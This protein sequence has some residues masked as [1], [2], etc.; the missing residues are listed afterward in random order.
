MCK[1]RNVFGR[2][3]KSK[4]CDKVHMSQGSVRDGVVVSWPAFQYKEERLCTQ[5]TYWV[6]PIHTA[7]YQLG[8][9]SAKNAKSKHCKSHSHSIIVHSCAIPF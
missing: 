9:I 2:V 5:L 3:S 4:T 8:M 7:S 6:R 1:M